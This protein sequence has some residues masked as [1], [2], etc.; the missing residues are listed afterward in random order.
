MRK[1]KLA[2]VLHIH[3]MPLLQEKQLVEYGQLFLEQLYK[4][5]DSN[6]MKGITLYSCGS[7]LNGL[8]QKKS[9][10][11]K[12]LLVES[13]SGTIEWLGGGYYDPVF[14]FLPRSLQQLQIKKLMDLIEN[15]LHVRPR[16]FFPSAYIW[17]NSMVELLAEN[18][19]EYT[20]LKDYQLKGSLWRYSDRA[21]YF[22]VE[23]RG[24]LVKVMPAL[25]GFM[26]LFAD[27]NIEGM[28]EKLSKLCEMNLPDLEDAEDKL[29][30]VDL[31][32]FGLARGEYEYDWLDHLKTMFEKISEAEL[33]VE[34][35]TL[36]QLIDSGYSKGGISIP[37]TAG[38]S[39]GLENHL[40]SCRELLVLQPEANYL[41][42]RMMH[43]HKRISR[44]EQQSQID[45]LEEMMLPVQ[46]VFYYRNSKQTGGITFIEDRVRCYEILLQVEERLREIHPGTG[47]KIEETDLLNNGSKQVVCTNGTMGF[48]LE[49]L[50]G[51]RLRSLEYRPRPINIIN[52]YRESKVVDEEELRFSVD[53]VSGFR[54][55]MIPMDSFSFEGVTR[56]LEGTQGQLTSPYDF[57]LKKQKSS[58]KLLMSGRQKF[59]LDG[60]KHECKIEK[61]ISVKEK[62]SEINVNYQVTNNTF[63]QFS[64]FFA[65]EFN[66]TLSTTN[67]EKMRIRV[68]GRIINLGFE[69][70]DGFEKNSVTKFEV[71]DK[72]C[73]V[74]FEWS[75]VKECTIIVKKMSI[76]VNDGGD[77]I[78]QGYT[79]V[80]LWPVSMKGQ[81]SEQFLSTVK[82]KKTRKSLR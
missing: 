81:E 13:Q 30:L 59:T 22:C 63:Y 27:G 49:P 4:V 21:G 71:L 5:L 38:R 8:I 11:F 33:P 31:P 61:V 57:T 48:V 18:H 17:E 15:N 19:F 69:M 34:V 82:I 56:Y 47:I 58:T 28:V 68:N 76:R 29:V 45:A 78:F 12:R 2:I 39:L 73:G 7:F 42:K 41:H 52:G 26:Q 1:V 50:K 23:D 43:L 46:G 53:P 14:P 70:S 67:E 75:F 9:D 55:W 65:N 64:G 24:R 10:L 60:T 20:L 54:D 37:E 40:T 51:G 35:G 74:L 72:K 44:L 32:F 66:V 25:D 62:A 3:D 36:A 6:S 16:G 80:A 79:C 77:S